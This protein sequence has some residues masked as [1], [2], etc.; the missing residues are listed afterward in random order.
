MSVF[1]LLKMISVLLI[2]AACG[3]A[4]LDAGNGAGATPMPARFTTAGP[5]AI[6]TLP[7]PR[8]FTKVGN[9]ITLDLNYSRYAHDIHLLVGDEIR[10]I[11]P[12][13]T[14]QHTYLLRA[15]PVIFKRTDGEGLH[16]NNEFRE[17]YPSQ[18]WVLKAQR[19]GTSLMFMAWFGPPLVI[20]P[21]CPNE[22]IETYNFKVYVQE[23][24]K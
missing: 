8:E 19:S 10:I 5:L 3:E 1:R 21:D 2:A 6:A 24:E 7:P 20:C 18:G 15:D 11:H 14:V 16:L 9:T 22:Y 17:F 12:N 23:A 4:D 13:T